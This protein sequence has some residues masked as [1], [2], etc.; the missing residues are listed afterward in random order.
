MKIEPNIK[1]P[2]NYEFIITMKKGAKK[3]DSMKFSTDHRPDI[4]TEVL[5]RGWL[6]FIVIALPPTT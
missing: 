4:L 5:V 6:I 3:T 1:A 2:N